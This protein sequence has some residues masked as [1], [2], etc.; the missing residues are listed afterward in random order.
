MHVYAHFSNQKLECVANLWQD[1]NS[2]Q[3][4]SND[5]DSG[6]QFICNMVNNGVPYSSR[7]GQH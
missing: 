3:F 1:G 4:I 2:L 5:T 7:T 6:V